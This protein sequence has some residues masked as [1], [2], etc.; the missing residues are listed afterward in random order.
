MKVKLAGNRIHARGF[1]TLEIIIALAIMLVVIVGAVNANIA[2]QYWT[3]T[4]QTS[5]EALY[6]AKTL[7]EQ[8]RAV[9]SADFQG[10]Q[11]TT[12][13]VST[14][15][16]DPADV[17]CENGGLCYFIQKKV[18]DISSCSKFVEGYVEW[19][20]GDRYPM[21]TES[22]YT[23]LTSNTEIIALGGDCALNAP[24]GDWLHTAPSTVGAL[25]LTPSGAFSTGMDV[26]Q[27][28]IY[29]T[30]SANPQL[31]IYS[32]PNSIGDAPT[33]LGST[34]GRDW[35][36]NSL[37]AMRDL[38]TGRTYAFATQNASTSQ[39]AVFDVT[40]ASSPVLIKER[41]LS[42]VD[43]LG[44]Y[45]EGWRIFV[46]GSRVYVTTR[47]TAGPEFHIFNINTPAQAT[48]VVSAV[49]ELNRTVSDMVVRE[50]HVS[51][52]V[53]RYTFLASSAGLKELSILDV[54]GDAST[55]VVAVDLPG[56]IDARSIFLN[57]NKLYVGRANDTSGPE[58]FV[59]D[60]PTLLDGDTDPLAVAEIG[61]GVET[62]RVSDE[63]LF[64]GTT[65]N[66]QQFQVRASDESTWSDTDVNAGLAS[67]MSV[68]RLAPL[69][70][71]FSG[72]WVYLLTQS[73]TQDE[74]VR[75]LYTP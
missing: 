17:V 75:V 4:S 5:N 72:D 41:P 74:M 64:L 67:A 56:S 7:L 54:T 46:Y 42:G 10:A 16:D 36:L 28:K 37:D 2:S 65:K 22:L 24:Q 49:Q 18:N 61:A 11:S 38:S 57:G 73:A 66:L 50:Q 58:L 39:L 59:F 60:V 33:L 3:I 71:D 32:V 43:M 63:L 53:H 14:D 62:I 9:A 69:G 68:P 23:N 55:E 25:T 29:L 13:T 6:K 20:S 40:D 70:V 27:K 19:D 21:T 47:E 52:S 1:N 30:S 26:L 34:A 15:P 31:R 12:L 8:L 48:E 35:Q 45:P 51:G 44:S